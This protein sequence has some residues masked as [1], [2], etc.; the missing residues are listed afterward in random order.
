MSAMDPEPTFDQ[1]NQMFFTEAIPQIVLVGV[2]VIVGVI[3]NALVLM[4]Y[5]TRMKGHRHQ[6]YFVPYLAAVDLLSAAYNGAG[7]ISL[8]SMALQV[9]NDDLCKAGHVL[10]F[11]LNSFSFWLLF[12]IALQRF[13][14]ICKPNVHFTAAKKYIVL[15]IGFVLSASCGVVRV[16][17]AGI[18]NF[19]VPNTNFTGTK[20][21]LTA[22]HHGSSGQKLYTTILFVTSLATVVTIAVLYGFVIKKIKSVSNRML[23]HS[24]SVTS[25][26]TSES[27]C[28]MSHSGS[29]KEERSLSVSSGSTLRR[30]RLESTKSDASMKM[31]RKR[32]DKTRITYM[33]VFI[34]VIALVTSVP[35]LVIERIEANNEAFFFSLPKV[36]RQFYMLFHGLYILN[37]ALN[38]LVYGFFDAVFKKKFKKWYKSF[39]GC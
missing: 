16:E 14:L 29:G 10:G 25:Q 37:N 1:L 33:F 38:P 32:T 5:A 30:N 19:T 7:K 27:E 9:V 8:Y 28:K 15:G 3:S 6:R 20:C 24:V 35:R 2:Y 26:S 21:S 11:I 31:R 39:F 22:N 17:F 13:L 4:I 23:R 36:A 18:T 12:T 34:T